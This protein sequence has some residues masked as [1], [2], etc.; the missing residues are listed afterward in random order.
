MDS[1]TPF[2]VYLENLFRKAN[3]AHSSLVQTPLLITAATYQ[4]PQSI[5]LSHLLQ[6]SPT[7]SQ[8]TPLLP[9]GVNR[10]ESSLSFTVL[11]PTPQLY[12][13]LSSPLMTSTPVEVT[14]HHI[15]TPPRT[16]GTA[17][18]PPHFLF[19][20]DFNLPSETDNLMIT[21]RNLPN[22][23]MTPPVARQTSAT[24]LLHRVFPGLLSPPESPAQTISTFGK[25]PTEAT[26]QTCSTFGKTP[27]LKRRR[28]KF[29]PS[30]INALEREFDDCNYI[31]TERRRVLAAE[32][33]VTSEN[34]RVWFQNRRYLMK[35][36]MNSRSKMA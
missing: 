15:P 1:Y 19:P 11:K 26:V 18:S 9:G 14:S 35:K 8:P 2:E 16:P 36:M 27:R 6:H 7:I 22:H 28:T 21:P 23:K 13:A 33:D 4:T 5:N 3:P 30:Q 32:L 12:P 17:A 10:R 24:P 20:P 31:T 29:T 25:T 34:I